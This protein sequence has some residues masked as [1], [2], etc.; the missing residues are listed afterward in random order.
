MPKVTLLF[1]ALHVLLMLAL[2]VP[3]AR[4]RHA[5]KVGLGDGG[6][7]LLARKIRVHG[8][9]TEYVPLALLVLALLEA[10]GL[11]AAAVWGFGGVLLLGR[12]LHAA[13]LSGSGGYSKG[14]FWGTALTWLSLLLM[15][16]AGLWIGLR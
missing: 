8:N 15:A 13:G 3:I 5:H 10:C 14:R 2:A 7:K 12:L 1:A 9:F 4:H 6:D 11:A 16:L